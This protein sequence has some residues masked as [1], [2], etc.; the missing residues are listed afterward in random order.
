MTAGIYSSTG[1]YLL[2]EANNIAITIVFECN[3]GSTCSGTVIN[4]N[5]I[6]SITTSSNGQGESASSTIKS[7]GQF[8]FTASKTGWT[9][10]T[11]FVVDIIGSISSMTVAVLS[12]SI[13]TYF[14]FSVKADVIGPDG[15]PFTTSI[16]LT[17]S[18][19]SAA[20]LNGDKTKTV[21]TGTATFDAIYY[22]A[23]GTFTITVTISAPY[24]FSQTSTQFTVQ[25]SYISVAFSGTEVFSI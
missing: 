3:T 14:A 8:K 12:P 13:Y 7:L 16:T 21:T 10:S 9:S 22:N 4:P 20:N 18:D 17:V 23:A 5:A 6:S 19:N 2:L 24:S 11:S 25:E 15:L 1:E